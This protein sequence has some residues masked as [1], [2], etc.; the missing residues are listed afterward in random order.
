MF[1]DRSTQELDDELDFSI[2]KGLTV[3]FVYKEHQVILNLATF[4]S[5]EQI[6]VDDEKVV[7]AKVF[8]LRSEHVLSVGD[9]EM[10]LSIAMERF[11]T[12][13]MIRASVAGEI[14]YE[15]DAI[16][17]SNPKSLSWKMVL[18]FAVAGAAVGYLTA[19]WLV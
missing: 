11:M 10:I 6:W 17:R 7:D 13:I 4:S 15:T 2:T 8:A 9:E 19:S 5:R 14:V 16:A 1:S 3:A 18:G 12:K